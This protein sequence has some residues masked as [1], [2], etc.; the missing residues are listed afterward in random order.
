MG[1]K[2]D[3]LPDEKPTIDFAYA[4]VVSTQKIS[5]DE[6]LTSENIWV[7]DPDPGKLKHNI[8]ERY[9]EKSFQKYRSESTIT[10]DGYN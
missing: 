5:K 2:K 3:I 4:C 1:G 6:S 9:L 7:K 10:M 8:I